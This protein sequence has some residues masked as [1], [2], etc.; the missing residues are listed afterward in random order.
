MYMCVRSILWLSV[1]ERKRLC[2]FFLSEKAEKNCENVE[3]EK[4]EHKYVKKKSQGE[5]AA[6]I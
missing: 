6:M 1:S 5:L 2:T 3:K 4:N